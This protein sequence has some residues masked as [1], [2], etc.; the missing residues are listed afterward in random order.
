MAG[1]RSVGPRLRSAARASGEPREPVA[2]RRSPEGCAALSPSRE[3]RAAR[4]PGRL[5]PRCARSCEGGQVAGAA[6]RHGS[7]GREGEVR[8]NATHEPRGTAQRHRRGLDRPRSRAGARRVSC[9]RAR[10]A[11]RKN[12]GVNRALSFVR[13]GG[14]KISC[15]RNDR[16]HTR[17]SPRSC[18]GARLRRAASNSPERPEPL[19]GGGD[20]FSVSDPGRRCR[21]AT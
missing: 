16:A 6:R 10:A 12:R 21:R 1:R 19:Q 2:W 18:K 7:A 13:R 20:E 5:P 17:S 11:R 3:L 9:S 4:E 8:A 14:Q 15:S